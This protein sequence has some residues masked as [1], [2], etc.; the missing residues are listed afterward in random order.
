MELWGQWRPHGSASSAGASTMAASLC[1]LIAQLVAVESTHGG[2]TAHRFPPD[3]AAPARLLAHV[4][5]QDGL[6]AGFVDP[7]H[8]PWVCP[9]ARR[10]IVHRQAAG[11]HTRT[12]VRALPCHWLI[13]ARVLLCTM[14]LSALPVAHLINTLAMQHACM[15][16][17]LLHRVTHVGS[18]LYVPL[19]HKLC[20]GV[21]FLSA[22]RVA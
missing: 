22:M 11:T 19:A 18:S 16:S 15:R 9:M 3:P 20:R 1:I 21:L 4:D 17:N 13:A 7:T 8:P 14:C 2:A 10:P 5:E 6:W 12:L